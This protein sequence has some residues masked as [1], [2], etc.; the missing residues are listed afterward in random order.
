[1][2]QPANA[3]RGND[4][5]GN[6]QTK[7]VGGMVNLAPGAA[8]PNQDG[9]RFWIDARVADE[10]EIEYQTIIA[11][12]Q[13]SSIVSTASDCNKKAVLSTKV[14]CRDN[15]SHVRAAHNQ[16]RAFIDHTVVDFACCIV[17]LITSLNEFSSQAS[18]EGFDIFFLGKYTRG[19]TARLVILFFLHHKAQA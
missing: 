5:T 2:C 13:S 6:R 12:S 7:G 1:K 17:M 8:T 16:E 14:D 15:V 10:R 9:S 11:D 3:G 18:L 19:T 4:S